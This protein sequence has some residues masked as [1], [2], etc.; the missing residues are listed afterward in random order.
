[1]K[2]ALSAKVQISLGLVSILALFLIFGRMLFVPDPNDLHRKARLQLGRSIV[3]SCCVHAAKN[4]TAELADLLNRQVNGQA[5][6]VSAAV[7]ELIPG[8]N[9]GEKQKHYR[10]K[11]EGWQP[12]QWEIASS[13]GTG[14][15]IEFEIAGRNNDVWGNLQLV[16]KP[17]R[18]AKPSEYIEHPYTQFGLFVGCGVFVGYWFFLG[19]MLSYLNPSKTVPG[20]VKSAYNSLQGGLLVINRKGRIV[21]ANS[22]FADAAGLTSQELFN[23]SISELP[24]SPVPGGADLAQMP[25]D[26]VIADGKPRERVVIGLK[27][28]ASLVF[29]SSNEQKIFQ[30][31]CAPVADGNEGV[32]VS[33]ED[34]TELENTRAQLVTAKESAESANEAKSSFL[35]NMS[36]EIRTP[37]N[38]I[39]GFTDILRRGMANNPSDR[40]RHLET[41]HSSG[42]HLLNLINDILDLSKVESGRLEVEQLRFNPLEIVQEVAK[43][44]RV[45]ADE[46]NITLQVKSIGSI[47]IGIESDPGRL[48]QIVTNLIG[49]AIKFTDQGGVTVE[50]EMIDESTTP[51]LLIR[52]IDSGI[53]MNE[54][55]LEKI[56]SPFAQADSSVT[57]KYGGTGLGLAISRRFATALGGNITVQSSPGE[58]SVFT[59]SIMTGDI[60]EVQRIDWN[61][62]VDLHSS[63]TCSVDF[64]LPACSVL[65]VEDGEENRE[66]ITLVLEQ[67]GVE[68]DTAEN[69]KIGVDKVSESNYDIIL[70]DMQMP[71]MDGYEAA[72]RMR[73]LGVEVPII[74][75][76][77]H[78][79]KGDEEKCRA[80]GCSG[81]LTKP[82]NIDKLIATLASDLAEHPPKPKDRPKRESA[83]ASV[84]ESTSEIDPELDAIVDT[85]ESMPQ[86]ADDSIKSTLPI[87]R[88]RFRLIVQRFVAR[89]A[90]RMF[91][92]EEC[93]QNGQYR[94][95]AEAAHWLKGA[96]GTVGF[97]VFTE[98][99][100]NLE[101]AA[102]S[103][104]SNG[105][106]ESFEVLQ[107]I[108][109]RIVCPS[110]PKP[111]LA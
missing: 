13:R 46:K 88:E 21:L 96:G 52:I 73:E 39:L 87:H 55:A 32:V 6:L 62:D 104:D 9:E 25:W 110:D 48:R 41:I 63:D 94:E 100:A 15:A 89:L 24:W 36:H 59:L 90:E 67:A 44:L 72:R 111:T 31:N 64:R 3:D 17:I 77:A 84:S 101:A 98:P 10:L 102:K 29:E 34:I 8:T 86:V 35:A 70:L 74:A 40:R 5:D 42:T 65:V 82:I 19:R 14:N 22:S 78:A 99:A 51:R 107:N 20:R 56:F 47:P 54:Q 83:I 61:D 38:A 109:Q 97:D 81:F 11:S 71:V 75:L 66:L 50:A 16:F 92:M 60:D 2:K 45:R 4:D 1:M 80:A 95:L 43:V 30:V 68:I 79:M 91:E 23:K 105:V 106:K 27:D 37:M 103:E 76:T 26:E 18:G 58:G 93:I 85:L 53:G 7:Y 12:S 49:N 28:A 69:G 108:S 57:R 33:L